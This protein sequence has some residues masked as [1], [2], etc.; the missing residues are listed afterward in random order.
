MV[1]SSLKEQWLVVSDQWLV[2]F[3]PETQPNEIMKESDLFGREI[4]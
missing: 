1:S 4:T 2:S 3:H